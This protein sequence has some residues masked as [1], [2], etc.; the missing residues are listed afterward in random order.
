MRPALLGLTLFAV[1]LSAG[2]QLL[3]KIGASSPNVR[4]AF[5][6]GFSLAS[7][8][9]AVTSPLVLTGLA[10]YGASAVLW[11]LVLSKL[12]L[13]VAY[14]FVG[15]GF[16]VTLLFGWLVLGEQINVLRVAGTLLIVGGVVLVAQS[17]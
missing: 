8:F 17:A 16:V 1:G 4:A 15:L 7:A 10:V 2:G 9:T 6:G 3:L 12:P 5:A 11:L 13:S 14:P